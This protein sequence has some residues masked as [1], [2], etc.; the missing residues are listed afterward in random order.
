MFDLDDLRR[1]YMVADRSL[2]W[3][4]M[5]FVSSI[6]GAATIGGTSGALNDPWDLQVFEFLRALADVIVVAAGTIR[7]E[8]YDGIYVPEEYVPWRRAHGL[9]DHPRLAIVT[10]SGDLDPASAPFDVGTRK[11][12]P[13][14]FAAS[15]AAI[16]DGL[17]EVAEV[18]LSPGDGVDLE[19]MVGE[20]H[21]RGLNQILS[22]GGPHLFGS[23]LQ[24]GLVDELCLTVSPKLVGGEAG[25]I[26]VSDDENAQEMGL[27]ATL[28]GG[29][30]RFE[31]WCR[32]LGP[33]PLS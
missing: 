19:W 29:V 10:N 2:P 20:L 8:N 33:T 11:E 5:N 6:D 15:D 16:A 28:T 32:T 17:E 24:A 30:M 12:R 25:R 27:V 14:V 21:A 13:L 22:E 7:D 18:L 9:S 1:T 26:A 23:M 31:R 3:V 4:R